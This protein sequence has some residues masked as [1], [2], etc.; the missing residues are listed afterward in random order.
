MTDLPH[1]LAEGV[2]RL[3]E[4]VSARELIRAS[5]ELSAKYREKRER[6]APV[7]RTEAEILAYVAS[8]LPATYAAISAVFEAVCEQRPDWTPRSVLDLGAG[9][10][11]GLWSAAASWPS[12]D[13]V[14]A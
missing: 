4:D 13:Q 2:E 12:I 6:R 10:G 1:E 7:A 11:T 3:L 5:A 9:P 8:R 14:V